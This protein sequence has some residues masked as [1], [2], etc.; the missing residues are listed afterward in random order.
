MRLNECP[1]RRRAADKSARSIVDERRI[2]EIGIAVPIGKAH[3]FDQQMNRLAG[4]K[5]ERLHGVALQHLKHFAQ[6][7]SA[8][9]R[10]RSDRI[11]KPR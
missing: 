6:G 8:R 4:M 10:R 3:R 2:A 1:D 11:V 7:D 5:A 9:T